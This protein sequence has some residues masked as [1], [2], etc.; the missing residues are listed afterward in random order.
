[1]QTRVLRF[2]VLSPLLFLLPNSLSCGQR[3]PVKK[4]IFLIYGEEK[5]KVPPA[6]TIELLVVVENGLLRKPPQFTDDNDSSNEVAKAYE[7]FRRALFPRGQQYPLLIGGSK[8]GSVTLGDL[9]VE[10][11]GAPSAIVTS[12]IP[13]SNGQFALAATTTE[14]LGLHADW[15]KPASSEERTEFVSLVADALKRRNIGKFSKSEIKVDRLRSTKLAGAGP[16]VLI[17]SAPAKLATGIHQVF[18]VA[19]KGTSGYQ[20]ALLSYHFAQDE[21]DASAIVEHLAEQIDLDGDGTDK[22]VAIN[23]YYEGYD[24]NIYTRE[25]GK[26]K[27]IYQGGGGS[28]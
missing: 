14:G 20:E 17:G 15:R 19:E 22:I 11:C 1:M 10:G 16:V 25:Q 7:K 2:L 21:N 8:K 23:T 27:K 9:S 13:L 5:G 3:S 24:F 28:C 12:S 26:W 18:L 6:S 4:T